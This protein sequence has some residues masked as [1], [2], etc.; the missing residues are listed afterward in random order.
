MKIVGLLFQS[1]ASANFYLIQILDR[2]LFGNVGGLKCCQE[3][4]TKQWRVVQQAI[5]NIAFVAK[6]LKVEKIG[7]Q[8]H[9]FLSEKIQHSLKKCGKLRY[10]SSF[11]LNIIKSIE[12]IGTPSQ[13]NLYICYCLSFYSQRADCYSTTVAN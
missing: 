6:C 5:S 13:I 11:R 12:Q 7:F 1:Q 2:R 8:C 9:I 10:K 4:Y 3:V